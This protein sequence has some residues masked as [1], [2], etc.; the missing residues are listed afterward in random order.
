MLKPKKSLEK[1]KIWVK[2]DD[3]KSKDVFYVKVETAEKDNLFD[4]IKKVDDAN[5]K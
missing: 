2:R 4:A 1:S 3:N 5:I